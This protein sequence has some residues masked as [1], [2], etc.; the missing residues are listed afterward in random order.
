MSKRKRYTKQLQTIAGETHCL[1]FRK[2]RRRQHQRHHH[3]LYTLSW[4]Y[5]CVCSL[6]TVHLAERI[7][8]TLHTQNTPEP[9][10]KSVPGNAATVP[11]TIP[12]VRYILRIPEYVFGSSSA[13]TAIRQSVHNAAPSSPTVCRRNRVLLVHY[14]HVPKI[15][16]ITTNLLS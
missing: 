3:H 12:T 4:W 10:S 5:Y 8:H 7:E 11:K 16:R 15:F 1:R 6:V 2:R 13:P 9:D 14:S